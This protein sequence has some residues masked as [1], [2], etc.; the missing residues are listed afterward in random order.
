MVSPPKHPSWRWICFNILEN[1]LEHEDFTEFVR[2][3]V[4]N[5]IDIEI[6]DLHDEKVMET[7][8]KIR[9]TPS[10]RR[11]VEAMLYEHCSAEKVSETV[12]F[13]FKTEFEP[14][15][16]DRYKSFFFDTENLDSV[17]FYNHSARKK[18]PTPPP[19]SGKF[20]GDFIIYEQGGDVYLDMDEV[21]Q[22]M[23]ARSFFESEKMYK[24]GNATLAMRAQ[25]VALDIY[26][27]VGTKERFSSEDG[28]S[29]PENLDITISYPSDTTVTVKYDPAVDSGSL[30]DG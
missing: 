12:N 27:A 10:M 7:M 9:N 18:P 3:V 28:E 30:E 2:Y 6:D 8:N 16:I 5:A 29:I 22:R 24:A 14:I 25:K 26:R 11:G 19:T 13:K 15:D 23:F 17:D 21:M 4:D 20:R 1:G